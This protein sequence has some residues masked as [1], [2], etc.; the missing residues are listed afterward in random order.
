MTLMKLNPVATKNMGVIAAGL[1]LQTEEVTKERKE[2]RNSK[3]SF[4]KMNKNREMEKNIGSKMVKANPKIAEKSVKKSG[5][6]KAESDTDK[7]DEKN[8]LTRT[9][10]RDPMLAWS[11]PISNILALDQTIANKLTK[12]VFSR[13]RSR[14]YLLGSPHG[15]ELLVLDHGK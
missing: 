13:C 3:K 15:H 9:W 5:S 6:R 2:R 10:S 1:G 8:N 11:S 12:L 14:P 7:G 4:T